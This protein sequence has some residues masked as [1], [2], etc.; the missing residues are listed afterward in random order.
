MPDSLLSLSSVPRDPALPD[1]DYL[2]FAG[3]LSR[4]EGRDTLLAAY[5]RLDPATRPALLLVGRSAMDLSSLPPGARAEEKWDH[6]RV[7]SGFPHARA[8]VLPI[9]VAGPLPDHG[10]RGDGA[11]RA[12]GDHA[13]G[14]HRGHGHRRASPR[15]SYPP[16]TWPPPRPRSPGSS[17]DPALGGRLAA[18]ARVE[19]RRYLQSRVAADF[20]EIYASLV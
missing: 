19:V 16:A 5:A 4:P 2:F 6:E 8:A 1:G 3:D 14:R 17:R 20:E 13:H 15:S 18:Q 10:A 12:A 7:V 11:R 9:E